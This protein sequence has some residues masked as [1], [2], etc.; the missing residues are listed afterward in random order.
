M[1]TKLFARVG[2]IAFVAIAITMSALQLR[3]EPDSAA[4]HVTKHAEAEHDGLADQLRQCAA[5]GEPANRDPFC[6]AVWFEARRHFFGMDKEPGPA[7][8]PITELPSGTSTEAA[9]TTSGGGH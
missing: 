4:E 5:M 6:R 3:E 9:T 1:D 2:A 8:E 7:S